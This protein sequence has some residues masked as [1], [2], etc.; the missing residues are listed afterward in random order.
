MTF[1]GGFLGS[2][3]TLVIHEKWLC[4]QQ[5]KEKSL[6]IYVLLDSDLVL[7][8]GTFVPP[9]LL[10]TKQVLKNIYNKLWQYNNVMYFKVFYWHLPAGKGQFFLVTNIEVT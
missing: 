10:N 1:L 9:S 4:F 3:I 7:V 8:L 5:A 6:N 2:V